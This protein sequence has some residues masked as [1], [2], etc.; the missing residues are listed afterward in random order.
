[1]KSNISGFHKLSPDERRKKLKENSNL[2]E[3]D[4]KK[5]E[6]Y[7]LLSQEISDRLVE[8]NV[9]NYELP[10]GIATNLT[11]NGKDYLV[12]MAIEESSVV[13]A[14][15]Y[16]AK[17]ARKGGGVKA[18]A[19]DPIMTGQI[20]LNGVNDFENIENILNNNKNKIL[21]KANK[22]DSTIVELGGGL[23]DFELRGIPKKDTAVLH[24]YIDV[25]DAMGANTVNTIA[26]N[27]APFIEEITGVR[28]NL[29]I[30]SNLSDK[31]TVTAELEVK[32]EDLARKDIEGE[33]VV[34]GI[35]D[36]YEFAYADPYRAATHN[37]GIMNGMDAVCIA[38][39]NDFRALEAGAHA[40]AARGGKYKPLTTWWKNETGD[41]K[42]KIELPVAVG[43]VGGITAIHPTAK[44]MHKIL[45]VDSAN[46]LAMVMAAVGLV[47]N[48]AALRALSTEGIQQGHMNLH[49]KNIATQA[50]ATGDL[51]E[52][53]SRKMIEENNISQSRAEKILEDIKK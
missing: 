49:A 32:K 39:G 46:E 1:M 6:K 35:I 43:T 2:N 22:K 50:G 42:G 28:T 25:R 16:G 38:T 10:L 5:L 18:K 7:G 44:L 29:K 26:E 52:K 4:I 21:E 19:T 27:I 33:E 14:C 17:L 34:D 3:N 11:V 30:L 48:L 47:Q 41:L 24:L 23:K 12:P 53:V 36:A 13:A 9:S 15:S 20:Q 8:N 45:N 40:Y 37:K 31:R 51:I